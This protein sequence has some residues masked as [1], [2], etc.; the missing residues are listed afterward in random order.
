M[1]NIYPENQTYGIIS[2]KYLKSVDFTQ[3]MRNQPAQARYS[4]DGLMFVI[5]WREDREPTFITD[6]KVVPLSILS[7]RACLKLMQTP[8]WSG[9]P[10][11]RTLK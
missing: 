1:S 8:E 11:S 10:K 4:V 3:V 9:N 6:K 2:T 7:H 5:K